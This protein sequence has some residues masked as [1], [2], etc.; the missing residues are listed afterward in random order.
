MSTP[1]ALPFYGESRMTSVSPS[2]ESSATHEFESRVPKRNKNDESSF[3][4]SGNRSTES[5]K[6]SWV[7]RWQL[8]LWP[9]HQK[10]LAVASVFALLFIA[11]YF[12]GLGSQ[13]N[14]LVNIDSAKQLDFQFQVDINEAASNELFAIPGIGAKLAER[15]VDYRRVHGK[16]ESLDDL[17]KVPGLGPKSIERMRP[18]VLSIKRD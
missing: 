11:I 13:S 15:I 8:V 1:F 9:A 12:G 4:P 6:T 16:F 17:K 18:F 10:W 7:Y 3:E 14:G 2:A 5:Q